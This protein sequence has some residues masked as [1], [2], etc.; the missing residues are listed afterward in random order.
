MENAKASKRWVQS[1]SGSGCS[2]DH[3]SLSQYLQK[4]LTSSDGGV[5]GCRLFP[6]FS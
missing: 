3:Y 6:E 2:Y 4:I 5:T 1:G